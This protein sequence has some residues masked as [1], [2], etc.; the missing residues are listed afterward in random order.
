MATRRPDSHVLSPFGPGDDDLRQWA[1]SGSL[2]PV[3]DFDV[4]VASIDRAPLLIELVSSPA[5]AFFVCCLYLAVGDAVRTSFA[6]TKRERVEA[7]LEEAAN[8]AHDP[9][10]ERWIADSRNLLAN[11]ET[12]DY[13]AWCG[14]GLA[15]AA[16]KAVR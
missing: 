14:G 6:T 4:M 2:A 1:Y 12:F 5:R 9:A 8:S 16:E 15:H 11:P 10:V 13:D 7:A 3:E